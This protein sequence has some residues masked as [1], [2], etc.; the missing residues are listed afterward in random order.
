MRKS[1]H[2]VTLA[3]CGLFCSTGALA[4]NTANQSMDTTVQVG[5][6]PAYLVN[7]MDK[8]EL[9]ESLESCANGPFYKTDFSI[10]HRGA[11]M[12][13][14]EHTKESYEAAATMGAGIIECDVT[15]T[16]D[17]ELV[18]RHS[19][20]DLHSTTNILSIPKLAAQCSEPFTPA[21]FDAKIEV[22]DSG[23]VKMFAL[24]GELADALVEKVKAITAEAEVG[25]VYKGT[26]KTIKDFGAFVEILPGTDGLVHISELAHERV[27]KVTD[28][29]NEGDEIE[30]KVLDVDNRGR[31][32]LS[33]KALLEKE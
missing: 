33:R 17:K 4:G 15:F 20:C 31:I 30:V 7:D 23:L 32:R 18:C 21:E 16:K 13:F 9:K 22:D 3:L 6:R 28:V 10:G 1:L 25:A 19:Q 14:P 8:G 5:V 27:A 29:L 26:V 11:S 2:L 24:S 12:Q